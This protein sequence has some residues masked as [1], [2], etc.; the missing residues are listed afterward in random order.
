MINTKSL[1]DFECRCHF[2]NNVLKL[3]QKSE[4]KNSVIGLTNY[5]QMDILLYSHHFSGWYC[6]DIVRRNSFSVIMRVGGLIV[7]ALAERV[8]P[9]WQLKVPEL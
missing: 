7:R 2:C 9:H 6:I 8:L 4:R 1:N 3:N 5:P